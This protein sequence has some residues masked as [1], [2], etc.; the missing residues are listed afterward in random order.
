MVCSR[1]LALFVVM[2]LRADVPSLTPIHDA[3]ARAK[4]AGLTSIKLPP[5]L[6]GSVMFQDVH[7]AIRDSH[8]V[9][10]TLIEKQPVLFTTPAESLSTYL[11]FRVEE[12]LR[13]APIPDGEMPHQ[14]P[15][16]FK[17]LG[18]TELIVGVPEAG[19]MEVD[20]I[21]VTNGQD[22]S[23]FVVGHRYFM[24]VQF[25]GTPMASLAYGLQSVW[26]LDGDDLIPPR[27][28]SHVAKAF[29]EKNLQSKT[30][31]KAYVAAH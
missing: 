30:R 17:N 1:V 10:A 25:S 19:Q 23:E 20:G 12:E 11:R 4:K 14:V 31:L 26:K 7:T 28:E 5:A 16:R 6:T 8:L 21:L 22:L 9:V 13:N 15:E 18:P 29:R 3:V 2:L 24:L 27:T